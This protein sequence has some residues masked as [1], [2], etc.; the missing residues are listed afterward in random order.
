MFNNHGNNLLKFNLEQGKKLISYNKSIFEL[1]KPYL[2]L[3]ERGSLVES[4]SNYNLS[5]SDK[6]S[7]E[8]LENIENSASK[9][10][11][12]LAN[13]KAPCLKSTIVG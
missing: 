1:T 13:W 2:K 4:M 11:K 5:S 8:G 9:I 6:K 3:I 10:D 12:L 7:I